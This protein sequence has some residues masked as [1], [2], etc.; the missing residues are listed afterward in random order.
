MGYGTE[1]A[2]IRD[3]TAEGRFPSGKPIV[4]RYTTEIGQKLTDQILQMNA[5]S[6]ILA[7]AVE[8]CF[9]DSGGPAMRD[10]YVVGDNELRIHQQ[11]PL[12]RRVPA[13]RHPGRA[14]LAARLHDRSF[15]SE[16]GVARRF[17]NLGT[18]G[19][20]SGCGPRC[21]GSGDHGWRPTADWPTHADETMTNAATRL[22]LCSVSKQFAAACILLLA[23]K[24]HL[25]D[26][27]VAI[28][29]PLLPR[30]GSR[31]RSRT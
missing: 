31:S 5:T 11:L 26:D 18:L 28:G 13:G 8:T 29:S 19:L 27:P 10:G 1:V 14:Q 9:G 16:Q 2:E 20:L 21:E 7:P 12:P 6:T 22:Q 15:L 25:V 23:K 4:R 24:G 3:R 17:A 30:R